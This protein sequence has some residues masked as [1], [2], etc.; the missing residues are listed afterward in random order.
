MGIPRPPLPCKLFI[1]MI[2]SDTGLIAGCK[3]LLVDRYGPVDLQ[4]DL[5]PW[6][7]SSYYQSEMG[8]ALLRSFIFFERPIDPAELPAIKRFTVDL[9]QERARTG[10]NRM[11]RRINLDPGYLTESK[12]VLATT[13]DFPHRI[14]IG[15]GIYAETTL[16]YVKQ[17]RSYQAIDHTYPDFR[18]AYAIS[19]FNGAREALR[20]KLER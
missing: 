13:K 19:L 12:V 18:T 20:S 14:Y 16:Q 6:D 4:S 1:G 17:T 10:D 5:L 11:Q 9:E 15:Q 3:G 2:S 7:H 8:R